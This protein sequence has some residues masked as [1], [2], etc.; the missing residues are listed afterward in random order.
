MA[1][2]SSGDAPETFGE[3]NRRR[4]LR[5]SLLSTRAARSCRPNTMA[6]YVEDQLTRGAP[7]LYKTFTRAAEPWVVL[8]GR[9]G[10]YTRKTVVETMSYE[11]VDVSEQQ[12]GEIRSGVRHL[13]V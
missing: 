1:R 9:P 7:D 10:Q 6:S 3:L 12:S 2:L 5:T 4:C 11:E 13:E 8:S